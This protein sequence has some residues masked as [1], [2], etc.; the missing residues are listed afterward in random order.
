[1]TDMKTP[2]RRSALFAV[3]FASAM[4]TLAHSQTSPSPLVS[5]D[6]DDW[7]EIV[8]NAANTAIRYRVNHAH[9]GAVGCYGYLYFDADQI[10]YEV[11]TPAS[12]SA[13]AFRRARVDLRISRHWTFLRA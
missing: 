6:P 7:P 12:D 10:W 3:I 5:I 4:G 8:H 9:S 1:P 13:H 2:A 11:A